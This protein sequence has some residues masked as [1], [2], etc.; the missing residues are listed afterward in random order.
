[1]ITFKELL[2]T[3]REA[4]LQGKD[5]CWVGYTQRGVKRKGDRTVPNCIPVKK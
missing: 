5:P 1:M 4:K 3:L 2:E